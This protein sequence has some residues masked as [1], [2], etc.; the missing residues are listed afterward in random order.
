MIVAIITAR[1][2]SKRLKN[3][4]IRIIK[5]M[6]LYA[7]AI[8]IL[9]KTNIF[10]KIIVS[11]DHPDIL[12]NAKKYGADLTLIRKKNLAD[13]KSTTIEVIQNEINELIKK[14]N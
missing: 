6:P 7:W 13:S 2:G 1:K 12:K 10:D 5:K 14:K 4:N 11:T 3:K 9:K 8:K